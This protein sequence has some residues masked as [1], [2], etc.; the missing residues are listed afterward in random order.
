MVIYR[1]FENTKALT[2]REILCGM[3]LW[4]AL[5]FIFPFQHFLWDDS[6][7]ATPYPSVHSRLALRLHIS[8][9]NLLSFRCRIEIDFYEEFMNGFVLISIEFYFSFISS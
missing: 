5:V 2:I 6:G 8:S 4:V 1:P 7:R 3:V 9:F